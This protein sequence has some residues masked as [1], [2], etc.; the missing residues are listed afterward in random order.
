MSKEYFEHLFISCNLHNVSTFITHFKFFFSLSS[1]VQ[2]QSTRMRS[3]NI[4]KF[5]AEG[6]FI[7]RPKMQVNVDGYISKHKH[8]SISEF[9]FFTVT[10]HEPN[11]LVV[12]FGNHSHVTI[13]CYCT[14]EELINKWNF[15]RYILAHPLS[16][17]TKLQ[18]NKIY[19]AHCR[20]RYFR[21]HIFKHY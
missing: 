15:N 18:T 3:R 10:A 6:I 16:I 7:R 20:R 12:K 21:S 1:H 8:K 11:I 14:P 13:H 5:Y 9:K 19:T 2:Q 4:L 17:R